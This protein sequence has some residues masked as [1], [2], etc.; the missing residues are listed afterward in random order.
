MSLALQFPRSLRIFSNLAD[1]FCSR[2][3]NDVTRQLVSRLRE[4]GHGRSRN[5][6]L[7]LTTRVHSD[8]SSGRYRIHQEIH[9]RARIA[10][11]VLLFSA[12]SRERSFHS[13]G[14]LCFY[15][16]LTEAFLIKL[17]SF[18]DLACRC[19]S[20]FCAV[21]KIFIRASQSSKIFTIEHVKV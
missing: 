1:Y 15:Q 14:F 13:K 21:C 18:C 3:D 10:F 16:P 20:S 19:G 4:Y 6:R 17:P 11:S 7:E 12:S 8:S 5:V 9:K 2:Q